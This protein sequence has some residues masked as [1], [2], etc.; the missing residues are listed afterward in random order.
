M[1]FIYY[2][3]VLS[4]ISVIDEELPHCIRRTYNLEGYTIYQSILPSGQGLLDCQMLCKLTL[5]CAYFSWNKESVKG[6]N[7][8]ETSPAGQCSLKT[9]EGSVR[10]WH[11]GA[12]SLQ[13]LNIYSGPAS[14]GIICFCM[15]LIAM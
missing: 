1:S 5:G 9:R 10:S 3:V 11:E 15:K 2:I 4:Y 6:S 12:S 7:G 13:N 14:C 8:T